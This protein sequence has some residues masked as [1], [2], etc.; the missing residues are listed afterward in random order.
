MDNQQLCINEE[1]EQIILCGKVGDEHLSKPATGK[2]NSLYITNCV[3]KEYVEYKKKILGDIAFEIKEVDNNGYKKG[4]IYTLSTKRLSYIT[5]IQNKNLDYI[6]DRLN[7]FGLAIWFYDDGS[8]H[9]SK[10]FYNLNTH[11]FDYSDNI[12]IQKFLSKFSINSKITKEIK[13][14]GREFYYQR[15]GKYDGAYVISKILNKYY[16]SCYSYKIW[17]S[18]TILKWSKLQEQLKSTN[19]VYTNHELGKIFCKI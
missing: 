14:D 6:L 15:I 19:K 17:S 18:E 1:Q 11:K 16:I 10:L 2:S 3:H 8:L 9:K 13:K 4:K 5:S 7:E 12:K